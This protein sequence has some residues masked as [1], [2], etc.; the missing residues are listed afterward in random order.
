MP[1][2]GAAMNSDPLLW[3]PLEPMRYDELTLALLEIPATPTDMR[4]LYRLLSRAAS[5]EAA[6]VLTGQH[7]ARFD[8]HTTIELHCVRS[9]GCISGRFRYTDK[10]GRRHEH[11]LTT[12]KLTI[13]GSIW[14]GDAQPPLRGW[15]LDR[16]DGAL[17]QW[18][19]LALG[20]ELLDLICASAMYGEAILALAAHRDTN[21]C[22][23]REAVAQTDSN[24]TRPLRILRSRGRK[25][26]K[27]AAKARN[28]H[29]LVGV[30]RLNKPC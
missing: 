15:L 21:P 12:G 10:S 11:D 16:A 17:H 27:S 20:Q 6:D 9:N 5:T 14:V 1:A 25:T 30:R 28:P 19:V 13:D 22:G 18:L 2:S 7:L 4:R 23:I 29:R 3:W 8:D 26:T 24:A